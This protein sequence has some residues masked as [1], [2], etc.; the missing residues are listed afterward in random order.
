M[1][2]TVN[3]KSMN[4]EEFDEIKNVVKHSNFFITVNTNRRVDKDLENP[5]VRK[6]AKVVI[7]MMKNIFDFVETKE[8]H[9]TD[10]DRDV[11]IVPRIERG[12]E[13]GLLHAHLKVE[14]THGSNIYL[15]F[16]MLRRYFI[17]NMNL[18]GVHLD[19]KN[20]K[21]SR[22]AETDSDRILR[23]MNK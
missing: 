3:I 6:F 5:F 16:E 11:E 19:V 4:L 23:Y 21:G 13:K 10:D 22:I 12:T 17:Q 2:R 7:Y 8:G 20:Y 9:P 1:S 14:I 18:R 15:N